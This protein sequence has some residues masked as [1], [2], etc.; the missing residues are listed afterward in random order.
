M[1]RFWKTIPLLILVLSLLQF[2]KVVAQPET[3]FLNQS[4]LDVIEEVNSLRVSKGLPPYQVNSILMVIAQEHAEYIASSGVLTYFDAKGS[5]PYQRALAAGYLVSGDLSLGGFFSEIIHYGVNLSASDVVGVWQKESDHLNIIISSELNDIGVG[6]ADVKGVTYYVLDAGASTDALS[7]TPSSPNAIFT[8]T[9]GTPSAM[10]ITSTPLEDGTVYH[11]VQPNEALWSIA[12]AYDIT[13][14][15]L[16]RLNSLSSNEIFIGQKLLI[17]KLVSSTSTPEPTITVTL[18]IATSTA[19]RPMP[20]TFTF[21]PTFIPTSP[22]SR[23]AG[24]L[25]VGGIVIIAMLAA[26]LGLW[27]GKKKSA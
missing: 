27:L 23:Q 26:G 24:G 9:A 14:E 11:I 12:Q 8:S 5:R 15:E 3:N 10:V 1:T 17:R 2:R 25:I 20:S 16:K 7:I 4:A 18:G 6:V 21:T 22:A 19:K 13:I